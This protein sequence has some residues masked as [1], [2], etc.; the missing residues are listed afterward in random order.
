MTNMKQIFN[1]EQSAQLPLAKPVATDNQS[2]NIHSLK[3]LA[4]TTQLVS[5]T[6]HKSD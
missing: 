1:S 2:D 4:Q 3:K 6:F 5:P